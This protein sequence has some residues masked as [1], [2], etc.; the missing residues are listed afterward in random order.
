MW[1]LA[2]AVIKFAFWEL[3]ASQLEFINKIKKNQNNDKYKWPPSRSVIMTVAILALQP[4]PPTQMTV[5]ASWLLGL[6][7]LL[8]GSANILI[9]H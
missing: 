9:L 2:S 8:T 7:I 1:F 3:L 4:P 5:S 6:C